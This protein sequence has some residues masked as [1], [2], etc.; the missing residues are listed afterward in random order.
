MNEHENSNRHFRRNK[1]LSKVQKS[2][3]ITLELLKCYLYVNISTISPEILYF[4]ITID[5]SN[6]EQISKFERA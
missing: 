5:L 2:N 1:T 3:K 6:N 4:C